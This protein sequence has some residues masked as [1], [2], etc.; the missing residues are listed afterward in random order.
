MYRY[1][2]RMCTVRLY[3]KLGK[4]LQATILEL[5]YPTRNALK[6]WYQEH[7]LRQLNATAGEILGVTNGP[8]D[9]RRSSL[10]QSFGFFASHEYSFVSRT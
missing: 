1:E 5:G 6:G 2:D 4:R 10:S 8:K 9:P 7:E 3:I